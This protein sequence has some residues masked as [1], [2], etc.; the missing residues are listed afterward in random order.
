MGDLVAYS[1]PHAR[2]PRASRSCA[3]AP[4]PQSELG[5]LGLGHRGRLRLLVVGARDLVPRIVL[6]RLISWP[7]GPRARGQQGPADL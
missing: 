1:G 5:P 6:S 7:N 3:G 2:G 4:Q